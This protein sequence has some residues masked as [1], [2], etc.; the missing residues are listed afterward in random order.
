MN[1]NQQS[2]NLVSEKPTPDF[3]STINKVNY[4]LTS[5]LEML[6]NSESVP[7]ESI[8]DGA[9]SM[10]YDL[11]ADLEA[12]FEDSISQVPK[13]VSYP[14]ETELFFKIMDQL[15]AAGVIHDHGYREN[16]IFIHMPTALPEISTAAGTNFDKDIFYQQLRSSDRF[17]Q[18]H[19]LKRS[20]VLKKPIHTWVFKKT[21]APGATGK[22]QFTGADTFQT[23]G[24]E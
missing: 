12:I 24:A 6:E 3:E 21:P 18:Q 8:L 16:L 9:I 11:M 14:D 2:L 7:N 20:R 23:G 4:L 22:D 19:N 10:K 15:L 5:L 13:L 1:G 17:V